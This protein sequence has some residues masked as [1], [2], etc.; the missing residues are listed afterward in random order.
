MNNWVDQSKEMFGVHWLQC[1]ADLCLVHKRSVQRWN[2]GEFEIPDEIV[3]KINKTYEIWREDIE[4]CDICGDC[5][6]KDSVPLSCQ[7]GDGE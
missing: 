7:S 3:L 6:D 2:S 1:L 4:S 5:H